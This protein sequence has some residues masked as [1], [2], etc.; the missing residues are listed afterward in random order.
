[1]V[2]WISL[3]IALRR[4]WNKSQRTEW[5]YRVKLIFSKGSNMPRATGIVTRSR[6]LNI[7]SRMMTRSLTKMRQRKKAMDE[8]ADVEAEQEVL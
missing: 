2:E 5:S 7:L 1:M 8:G 6:V 4:W 3:R